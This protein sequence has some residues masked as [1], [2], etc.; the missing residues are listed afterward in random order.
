MENRLMRFSINLTSKPAFDRQVVNTACLLFL[1]LLSALLILN[2]I[3]YVRSGAEMARIQQ[4][5]TGSLPASSGP[6]PS[7]QQLANIR[8]EIA[9][10]NQ[11]I[12]RKTRDNL[13]LLNLLEQVLPVGVSLKGLKP[14]EKD[15]SLQLEG[16]A[17][18][19]SAMQACLKK[20]NS[21]GRFK[22]VLLLRQSEDRST[23]NGQGVEFS[24]IC[25]VLE[26]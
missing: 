4:Q 5:L 19:V 26:L 20:L 23:D 21:S 11:I 15:G 22:N 16:R 8:D 10:A 1:M 9:F 13:A 17:R 25:K 7:E 3:R 12:S 24:I 2:V 14:I 6:V 18:N